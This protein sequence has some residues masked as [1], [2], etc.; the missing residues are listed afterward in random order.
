VTTTDNIVKLATLQESGE[1]SAAAEDSIALCFAERHAADLRYVAVMGRWLSY[2]GSR[3]THDTT[4][5][6]FDLVREICREIARDGD[7]SASAIASAKTVAAVERLAKADRRLAATTA[8]WDA[9]AWIINTGD[10]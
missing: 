1:I 2:D 7:K 6:A 8:Q 10:Q 3:W 9:Y 4:L 5:H